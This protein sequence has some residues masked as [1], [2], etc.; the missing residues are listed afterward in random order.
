MKRPEQGVSFDFPC[1]LYLL[2]QIP[3]NFHP[4]VS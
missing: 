4:I 3:F 2:K 1:A